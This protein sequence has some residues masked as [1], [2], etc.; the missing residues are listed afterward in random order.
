MHIAH[1]WLIVISYL[2]SLW[3]LVRCYCHDTGSILLRKKTQNQSQAIIHNLSNF[4]YHPDDPY[5]EYTI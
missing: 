5:H 2:S 4:D 1:A 3:S